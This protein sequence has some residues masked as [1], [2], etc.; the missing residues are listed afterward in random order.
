MCSND[1]FA[2]EEKTRFVLL[3]ECY[4]YRA[5]S[6]I[7]LDGLLHSGSYLLVHSNEHASVRG[8]YLLLLL[9]VPQM[10]KSNAALSN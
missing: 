8:S 10:V 3:L 5:Q 9:H 2:F 1:L 7:S 6:R 4:Y